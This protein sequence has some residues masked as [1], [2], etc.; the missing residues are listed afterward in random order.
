MSVLAL[1]AGF[2]NQSHL[3]RCMRRVAGLKPS[4]VRRA[5]R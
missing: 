3:A 5:G 2:A 1:E 4:D